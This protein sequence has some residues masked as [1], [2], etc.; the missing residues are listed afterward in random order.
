MF[1]GLC[2]FGG[3]G[4]LGNFSI[5]G[6][7]GMIIQLV[8]WTAVIA[9]IALLIVWVIRRSGQVSAL[10]SGYTNS[11]PTSA[12]DILQARYARGEISREE[13]QQMLDDLNQA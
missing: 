6:W 9:G 11:A 10:V 5:W 4:V 8:L 2:H 13:Y 1:N 3:W 7:A 12:K